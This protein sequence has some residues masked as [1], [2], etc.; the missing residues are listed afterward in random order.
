MDVIIHSRWIYSCF[1]VFLENG[2]DQQINQNNYSDSKGAV[3][4]F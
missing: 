4:G 1:R 3:L 2:A